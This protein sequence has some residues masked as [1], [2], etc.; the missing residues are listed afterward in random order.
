MLEEPWITFALIIAGTAAI[1]ASAFA[2]DW[3]ADRAA[4]RRAR[5]AA[6]HAAE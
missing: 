3:L 2:Q 4:A 5:D 1:V 6:S